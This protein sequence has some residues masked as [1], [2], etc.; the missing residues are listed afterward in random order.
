MASFGPSL[1]SD[2]IRV[3]PV[4]AFPAKHTT[5]EI[6]LDADGSGKSASNKEREAGNGIG[7]VKMGFGWANSSASP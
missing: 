3:A 2:W 5:L 4:V 6:S 1:L 7:G